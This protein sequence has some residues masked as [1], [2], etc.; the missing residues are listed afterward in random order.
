MYSF[1]GIALKFILKKSISKLKLILYKIKISTPSFNKL[2]VVALFDYLT[3]FQYYYL[4]GLFYRAKAVGNDY[5]RSANE[6]PVQVLHNN[7]LVLCIKGVCGLVKEKIVGILVH[8][9]GYQYPLF[10]PCAYP[11]PVTTNVSLIPKRQ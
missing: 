7:P 10:L 1:S 8:R 3:F 2:L 11:V 4:V 5:N 9:A 6:K